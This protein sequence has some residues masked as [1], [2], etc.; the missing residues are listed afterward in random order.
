MTSFIRDLWYKPYHWVA[1]KIPK[2]TLRN[3]NPLT[4]EEKKKL[5][6]LLA[7]GYYIILTSHN[8]HLSSW[9][10]RWMY[11]FKFW[12]KAEFSHVLMNVDYLDKPEE[13]QQFKFMEATYTGVH[14]S[15]FDEVFD[16][17]NFA[18]LSPKM[19]SNITFTNVID[20]LVKQEGKEYDDLFQLADESKMSCV[21]L[22]RYAFRKSFNDD[23]IYNACFPKIEEII[24]I[25]GNL[26]PESFINSGDFV[27]VYKRFP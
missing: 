26:F 9:F 2:V 11:F 24:R 1:Q 17:T 23:R 20:A 8:Y 4:E 27:V 22:I 21:E 5:A 18:L 3:R 16:C 10:V 7:S 12:N 14:Y 25:E 15:K 13:L 6:E 19:V